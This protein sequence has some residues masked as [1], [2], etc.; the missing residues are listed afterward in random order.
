MTITM[1]ITANDKT[2]TAEDDATNRKQ[3]LEQRTTAK[4]NATNRK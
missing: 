2:T 1:T 3:E 4:E